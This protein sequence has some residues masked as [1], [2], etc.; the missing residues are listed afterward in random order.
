MLYAAIGGMQLKRWTAYFRIIF[1]TLKVL[2]A[3]R[4]AEGCIHAETF[5]DG[6]VF[7]AVSVWQ[8][9]AQMQSFARSGLHAQ[10]MRMAN[11]HMAVFFNHTQQFDVVP[12]REAFTAAWRDK[13]AERD[14]KGTVGVYRG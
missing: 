6:D 4:R 13:I 11:Q 8:S 7:F 3:A 12:G 9:K 2:K 5:K 14:G 10:L 1:P